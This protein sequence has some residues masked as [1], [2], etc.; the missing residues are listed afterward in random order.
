MV[1]STFDVVLFLVEDFV[2]LFDS[3]AFELLL[4]NSLPYIYEQKFL[5]LCWCTVA[6]L[7]FL[8]KLHF[9]LWI[10]LLGLG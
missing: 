7:I 5:D 6:I 8:I 10:A 2:D 4:I 9:V 3:F 1:L